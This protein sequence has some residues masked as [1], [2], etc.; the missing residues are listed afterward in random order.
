VGRLIR[1]G[2]RPLLLCLAMAIGCNQADIQVVK[3]LPD[4]L[5]DTLG[6]KKPAPTKAPTVPPQKQQAK[7]QPWVPPGWIPPG[8]ISTRWQCIVIHHSATPSG[9]A[10]EFHQAHLARG[11]DE[12]GYHFVIGNGTGSGDG[13]IEVGPRWYK[14]KH[15]AHCKTAN[16]YH[17]EH[18]IGICLVGD[19][20]Q[21]RPT[22]AQMESLR[23]LVAFLMIKCNIP[24]NQVIGHGEAPGTS[25]ACPGHN[26][27]LAAIRAQMQH[28]VTAGDF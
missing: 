24:A 17:N 20:D 15:G 9:S 11:W 6:P 23:R 18:G 7:R 8:G 27:G 10:A 12:L 21:T 2:A 22:R 26:L 28:Y 4:P 1:G 19:F 5:L 13:Q 16:N 14:Q 25:T 3:V